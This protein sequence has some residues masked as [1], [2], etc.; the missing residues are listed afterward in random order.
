[1]SRFVVGACFQSGETGDRLA[2]RREDRGTEEGAGD[3]ADDPGRA[4]PVQPPPVRCEEDRPFGALASRQIDRPGGAGRASEMAATLPPLRAIT[5]VRW[6]R[7]S[8]RCPM[9]APVASDTRRPFSASSEIRASSAGGPRPAAT[10]M[11][12]SSMRRQLPAATVQGGRYRAGPA[13]STDGCTQAEPPAA[14]L[15][16]PGGGM[17]SGRAR[18]GQGRPPCGLDLAGFIVSSLP[19][20]RDPGPAASSRRRDRQLGRGIAS[21][22]GTNDRD[23]RIGALELLR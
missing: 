8:P 1:M 4:V 10:R 16:L 11:A 21:V 14:S 3:P 22:M 2:T 9:S 19:P 13:A 20:G 12:P 17:A 23:D 5:R 7:S 18:P 15:P 6:P